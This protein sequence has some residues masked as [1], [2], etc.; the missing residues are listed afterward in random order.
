MPALYGKP[1]CQKSTL[2]DVLDTQ[3]REPPSRVCFMK[4]HRQV[5]AGKRKPLDDV[6][7]LALGRS[8]HGKPRR[9]VARASYPKECSALVSQVARTQQIAKRQSSKRRGG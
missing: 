2:D 8:S 1:A 3:R 5:S 9:G 7:V 4:N 6:H